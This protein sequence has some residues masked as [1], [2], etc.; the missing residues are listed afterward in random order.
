MNSDRRKHYLSVAPSLY[1]ICA[2]PDIVLRLI[3]RRR[4]AFRVYA[5]TE[6]TTLFG[7]QCLIIRWGRI[8]RSR[9]RTEVFDSDFARAERREELLTRRRQHG[10]ETVG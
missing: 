9:S 1:P 8:G 3:D 2:M 4:N 5:I 6:S 7:E 10:Y